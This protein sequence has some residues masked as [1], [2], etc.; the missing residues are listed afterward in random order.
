[1]TGAIGSRRRPHRPQQPLR[2]TFD[3]RRLTGFAG[4]T[5]A[6]ALLANGV[7]LRRP[8]LQVPPPARHR[9]RRLRGAE[10]AG[11]RSTRRGRRS[12]PNLRA[13]RSS[14][15]TACVAEARTA[16]RRSNSTS[17]RSTDCAL[18]AASAP[19]ST[20]RPSCGRASFWNR[21][22]SRSSA[23]RRP[24]PRAAAARSRPLPAPPRPLRRAGGRRR[25]GRARRG[26]AAAR[27]RPRVILATSRP[28]SAARCC[29]DERD[30]RRP[31]AAA[32]W[33]HDSVAELRS[34]A[35]RHAA[36]AH[37]GVRLSTTTTTSGWSSAS[38]TI[39]RT[40]RTAARA[41]VAGACQ[42]RSCSRPARIERPLVVRRQRP[43]RH[44]A[45]RSARALRSIATACAPGT[46]GVVFDQQRRAP[47][48]RRSIC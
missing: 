9:D 46:R 17:A 4:D 19:A 13:T 43:A 35:Q 21:S 31:L 34:T 32:G 27:Q 28:S 36:A 18:A 8:L 29:D 40:D 10:R 44:H 45:G 24:R 39:C 5:L 2:F 16:G 3:G 23:R 42:A 20:T 7:H 37:H 14:C 38:P 22:T 11:R 1:M 6:S 41:P 47:T 30:D 15:T 33:L 26:V 48:A 25:P 12:D